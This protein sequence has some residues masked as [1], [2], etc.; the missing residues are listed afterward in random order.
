MMLFISC[1]VLQPEMERLA[2]DIANPPEMIFLEQRLHD[3]PEKLRAAIQEEVDNIERERPDVEAIGLGYGLCGNALTGVTS[4]RVTLIIPRLHDCIP[5]LLGLS[6]DSTEASSRDGKTYWISPGW[7]QSFLAEFHLTD[8]RL[9]KYAEKFG[10]K[11][12]EKM[13]QAENALLTC[14][15]TACHIRWPEMGD[16]W[17]NQARDVAKAANLNYIERIGKSD[18]LREFME[19]GKDRDKFLYLTPGN[20]IA[21]DTD[22]KIMISSIEDIK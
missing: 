18:Y 22:G 21:M 20:T 12:A 3:Y 14:Y 5:F 1:E 11:R 13:V 16:A 4:K 19:G 17:I 2:Q 15:E 6:P 9:R 7:L 8:A 10:E